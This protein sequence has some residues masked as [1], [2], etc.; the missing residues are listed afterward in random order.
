MFLLEILKNISWVTKLLTS[1]NSL[2][3][4]NGAHMILSYLRFC[5]KRWDNFK[6]CFPKYKKRD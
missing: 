3:K 4:S 6:V 2:K 1:V 5:I